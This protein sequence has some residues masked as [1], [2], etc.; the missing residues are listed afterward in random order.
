MTTAAI[1]K[2]AGHSR[3]TFRVRLSST[4]RR[5]LEGEWDRCRWVWNECVARSKKA[6]ADG[7]KVGPA[8]LDKMLTEA[9]RTT[10]WL[11]VGSSVP[12][13]QLVRDFGKSRAKAV[14]DIKDR[15]PQHGKTAVQKLARY[16]RMMARRK[17]KRGQAAS[18]GYRAAKAQLHKRPSGAPPR[19]AA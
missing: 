1:A 9:R 12:Q 13:Q 17:P 7:E 5:A 6:H 14:K 2:G 18:N 10:P 11:A 4:A 8:A 19:M 3:F 16:Q 15:V